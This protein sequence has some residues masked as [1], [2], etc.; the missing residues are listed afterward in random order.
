MLVLV[1]FLR[2]D[3]LFD[4]VSAWNMLKIPFGCE[5]LTVHARTVEN[6]DIFAQAGQ[7]RPSESIRGS[8][9]EL[10]QVVVA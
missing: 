3:S 5:C 10:T 4:V 7:S 8:S 2:D 9:L 1:W 6:S